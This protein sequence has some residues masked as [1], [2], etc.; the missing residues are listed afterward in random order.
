MRGRSAM[1]CIGLLSKPDR[2]MPWMG[3]PCMI[4]DGS[5][6]APPLDVTPGTIGVGG[7]VAADTGRGTPDEVVAT[8]KAVGTRT[9]HTAAATVARTRDARMRNLPV[10]C[11]N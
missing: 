7:V 10:G 2:I 5:A 1:A 11:D 9:A 3:A 6:H 8:A 4:P